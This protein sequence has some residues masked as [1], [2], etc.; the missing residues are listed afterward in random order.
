MSRCITYLAIF[1]FTPFLIFAHNVNITGRIVDAASLQPLQGASIY[2][3]DKS[4]GHTSDENGCFALSVAPDIQTK[5]LIVSY[6]GYA[7]S[8]TEYH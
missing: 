8:V 2:F 6:V 7:R 4:T 3:A 1:L 5:I